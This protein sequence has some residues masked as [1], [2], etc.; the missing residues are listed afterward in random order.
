MLIHLPAVLNK[1]VGTESA[2][3]REEFYRGCFALMLKAA[4]RSV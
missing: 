3:A 1:H 2:K 4:V